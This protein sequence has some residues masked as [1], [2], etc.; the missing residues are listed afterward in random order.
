MDFNGS[1]VYQRPRIAGLE[2]LQEVVVAYREGS[3]GIRPTYA[4]PPGV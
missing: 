3:A 4:F 2:P 1:R